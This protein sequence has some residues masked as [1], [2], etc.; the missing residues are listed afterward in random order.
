MAVG[1]C[2]DN[3]VRAFVNR[4]PTTSYLFRPPGVHR[5]G[6][7]GGGVGRVGRGEG[8]C[9]GGEAIGCGVVRVCGGSGVENM[10][11]CGSSGR[12]IVGS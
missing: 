2:R 4:V 3:G 8:R 1:C 6:G 12:A 11:K 10:L 5:V 7:L 9:G